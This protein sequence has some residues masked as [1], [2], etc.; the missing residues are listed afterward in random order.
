MGDI[1]E[2]FRIRSGGEEVCVRMAKLLADGVEHMRKKVPLIW[3][4]LIQMTH[5]VW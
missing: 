1:Q 2:Q 4:D 3:N 5:L